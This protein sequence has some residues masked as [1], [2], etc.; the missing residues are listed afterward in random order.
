MA[1]ATPLAGASVLVLGGSSGIGLATA[2]AAAA[3]GAEVAIAGRDGERLERAAAELGGA[4]ATHALDVGEEAAVAQLFERLGAVD[5][6]LYTA[7]SLA[8]APVAELDPAALREVLDTRFWGAVHLAKHGAPRIREGGSITLMSGTSVERPVAGGA[9]G[10]AAVGAIEALTRTLAV[11]LAPLRVNCLRAG[12]V[13][14]PLLDAFF[15]DQR[16]AVVAELGTGLPV[17]RVGRPEDVAA[18]A[19][20][21]MSNGYATGSTLT[22]DGGALLV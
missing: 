3:A 14:T 1:E 11:E 2:R 13:D 10:T 21:L 16:D 18:A 4:V 20:F 8:G 6:V 9:I 12:V 15:G 19:L 5:H 7:G 17:G 22:L